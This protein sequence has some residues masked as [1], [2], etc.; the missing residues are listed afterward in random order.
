MRKLLALLLLLVE[1]ALAQTPTTPSVSALVCAYNTVIPS[2][3]AGQFFYVQC[4]AN[5]KLITSA[6][7]AAVTITANSTLTSGFTAGQ[8]L[9]SDGTKVQARSFGTGVATALGV[10]IG[11]AGAFVVNGG[12]LGTPSSGVA[13]NLTG[14]AA[15]LNAGNVTNLAPVVATTQHGI[16]IP[17]S[18]VS[19]T[20][21]SVTGGSTTEQLLVTIPVPAI[22]AGA[23][24]RL[25]VLYSLTGVTGTKTPR[26]YYGAAASGL[27]G[28]VYANTATG[29]TIL[30]VISVYMIRN[31]TTASQIGLGLG[32]AIA[33]IGNATGAAVTSSVT[34]TTATELNISGQL[35]SALDTFTLQGY[36]LEIILP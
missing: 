21:A 4:D 8:Y 28:T 1:P 11:T 2:P 31:I 34:T 19:N 27:G 36:T 26:L 30:S 14:T 7:G 23:S 20:P 9:Y 10:N 15:S 29:T 25:T 3:V 22:P 18:G 24:L 17:P 35:S 32:A 6:S 13:T 12:A 16:V 33:G 5:G